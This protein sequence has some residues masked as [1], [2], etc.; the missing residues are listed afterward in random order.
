MR[1]VVAFAAAAALASFASAPNTDARA[2]CE[3]PSAGSQ[4]HDKAYWR[5]IVQSKYAVPA[6]ES[7][8]KLLLELSDHLGSTDPE[9]RD[10]FG[11]DV[12]A[13]WIYE[14]K[15]LTPDELRVLVRKW[16]ANLRVGIGERDTDSVLLRSFS[17]LDLSLIAAFE[18][19]QPFFERAEFEALL[20]AALDYLAHEK[21][22]RG[23][24]PGKG[25]HHS[26]AHT[27][28]LLKFLA[29][30]RHLQTAEQKRILDAVADKIFSPAIGQLTHGEDE[31]LAA[32]VLSIVRREDFDASAFDAWLQR[33]AAEAKPL[34]QTPELD[35]ARFNAVQNGKNVLK[36]LFVALASLDAPSE[37]ETAARAKVL[38]TLNDM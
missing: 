24:V 10:T 29:H 22:V 28:D 8:S 25:W 14:Q 35:L 31:R 37:R 26:V 17:A 20:S 15:L 11:Y 30:N 19:K 27:A 23:Y 9:W 5:Q 38:R 7:A 34:W 36:S 6:G 32:T 12:P 4:S 1:Y 21:D 3:R 2:R 33:F 16:T 18:L 13:H